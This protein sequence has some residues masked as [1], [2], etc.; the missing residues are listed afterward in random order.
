MCT[1][2]GLSP[3]TIVKVHKPLYGVPE[4]GNHWFFTYLAHHQDKLGAEVSTYD[5]CL[6]YSNKD[7]GFAVIALQTDDTLFVADRK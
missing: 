1:L 7:H 3:R 5:N 4:A 6:L 2:L